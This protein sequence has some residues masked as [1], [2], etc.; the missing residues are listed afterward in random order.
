MSIHLAVP[1]Q[2]IPAAEHAL[3]ESFCWLAE[4]ETRLTRFN[5]SS[6]L[7]RLNRNAGQPFAASSMLLDCLSVALEAAER[8]D[9]LYDPALLPH[10]EAAGYA[11][12]FNEIAHQD[13]GIVE[14]VLPKT[15]RW[16]EIRLD[17][18]RGQVTL[19]RMRKSIWGASRKGG[20]RI[21]WP[22]TCWLL[23]IMH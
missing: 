21:V 3:H 15:G 8:T 2:Q 18:A 16:R 6:E 19:P 1:T 9:G 10:L 4:V 22:T 23:S 7:M 14:S 12:D 5:A 13:T 17:L 11:Q 20:P